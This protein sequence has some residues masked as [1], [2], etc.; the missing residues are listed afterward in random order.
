MRLCAGHAGSTVALKKAISYLL[1]KVGGQLIYTNHDFSSI[2]NFISEQRSFMTSRCGTV[3]FH[4]WD[5]S[6][7]QFAY[8]YPYTYSQLQLFLETLDKR[9][10]DYYK[11]E[12]LGHSVVS[13]SNSGTGWT[14]HTLSTREIVSRFIFLCSAT[15]EAGPSHYNFSSP[16]PRLLLLLCLS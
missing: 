14:L 4:L 1:L 13:Y 8:C 11:R 3:N 16:A 6:L 9:K 15:E 2:I 12:L 10:L 5:S 7:P